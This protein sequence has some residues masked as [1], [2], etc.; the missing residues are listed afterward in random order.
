MLLSI[1]LRNLLALLVTPANKQDRAQV[2]ELALSVQETTGQ[3]VELAFVDQG[4]T[5]DILAQ[6]AGGARHLVGRCQT[7]RSQA[8]FCL[9]AST[10]SLW[11]EPSLGPLV[12]GA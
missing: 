8:R 5:G 10:L 4:S 12:S 6:V 7:V 1:R 2:D 9:V 3:S 11:S